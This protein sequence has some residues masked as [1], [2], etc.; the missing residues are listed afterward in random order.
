ML[1]KPAS[2]K[3]SLPRWVIHVKKFKFL[4]SFGL[5]KR[6]FRKAF[7]ITNV[8]LGIALVTLVNIPSLI[9]IFSSDD[10]GPPVYHVAVINDTDQPDYP[11]QAT[12]LSYFDN[13][14]VPAEYV[15]IEWLGGDSATFWE[16]EAVDILLH[17]T[18]ALN[19][20]DVAVYLK[21]QGQAAFIMNNTQQFLNYFQGIE[22]ATF[23]VLDPPALDPGTDPVLPPE[24]RMF[25]DAFVSIMF[26]PMFML[27]IFATQF[28][29]VDII[30]EKSSK[31]I[32]TIISSVP[33]K[34]HFLSKIATSVLFLLIQGGL[35]VIFSILGILLG[36]VLV[37][38][39][40]STSLSFFAE[41]AKHLPNWPAILSISILFMLV[42]TLFFL[43]LSALVAAIATTQED[44]QQFQ[45]PLVLLIL[46][47]FYMGIFLPMIGVEGIMKVMAF[48]PFFSPFVGPIAY[49]T[50][51]MNVFEVL[52]AL[53]VLI[54]FVLGILYVVSPI[55]RIAILSYEETKFF[56]RIGLYVR[57][58]FSKAS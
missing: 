56:K 16:V 40:D 33:A 22:Y 58:A 50:G 7:I 31:A 41:L 26:L 14:Y 38:T 45:A 28:L 39:T 47:G 37:E 54:I 27:I 1:S 5:K 25:L 4:V 49:A 19:K 34:I 36:R 30:E 43:T 51:V 35:L 21:D 57:K 42:G 29:G 10:A 6:L 15:S 3:F 55:Y 18:G 20:P 12:L 23:V 53:V 44:Y 13:P 9:D 11:L 8:I 48:V 32:E 17:F 2:A 24:S 46:S 52:I